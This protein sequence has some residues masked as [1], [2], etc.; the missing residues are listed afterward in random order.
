M[1]SVIED[2]VV[3]TVDLR[4]DIKISH[5][6]GDP[7]VYE[8]NVMASSRSL[9]ERDLKFQFTVNSSKVLTLLPVVSSDGV[10]PIVIEPIYGAADVTVL[11]NWQETFL[12]DFRLLNSW[13]QNYS[14][15]T[16]ALYIALKDAFGS[17]AVQVTTL[18]N[19]SVFFDLNKTRNYV[20]K[21]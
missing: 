4:Q 2:S 7:N 8:F 11:H 13:F 3:A 19:S 10:K 12:K 17:G 18:G 6:S 14:E 20:F 5:V 16:K 21:D 15:Y 9:G 1:V